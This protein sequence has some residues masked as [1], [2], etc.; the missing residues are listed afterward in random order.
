MRYDRD[1]DMVITGKRHDFRITYRAG[2][3]QHNKS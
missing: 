1:D 2:V 3:D